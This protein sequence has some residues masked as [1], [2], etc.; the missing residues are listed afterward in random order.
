M[1]AEAYDG[2]LLE[3]PGEDGENE[4]AALY[5]GEEGV[6]L[7]DE[8][9]TG[10]F[11][12]YKAAMEEMYAGETSEEGYGEV[13]QTAPPQHHADIAQRYGD[14]P[15]AYDAENDVF[16]PSGEYRG[17]ALEPVELDVT[18]L[19]EEYDEEL[20]ARMEQYGVESEEGWAP[21][22][23]PDAYEEDI[24]GLDDVEAQLEEAYDEAVGEAQYWAEAPGSDGVSPEL[25][26]RYLEED[27]N[28]TP[29]L[30]IA[31]VEQDMP[32][33]LFGFTQPFGPKVA[34]VN[35]ALY[36]ID[37]Q[38][39]ELHEGKN[40]KGHWKERGKDEMTIRYINGDIDVQNTL[41]FQANNAGRIGNGQGRVRPYGADSF[42]VYGPQ[43]AGAGYAES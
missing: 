30:E 40:G 10:G 13:L 27:E 38:K 17:D 42:G 36:K 8:N 18:R 6:S 7:Y 3:V 35:K 31:V 33:G 1:A 9:A 28:G 29:Y 15:V 4:P 24:D 21:L 26:G 5:S 34:H 16:V 22:L 19:L 32:D 25:Y 39:T 11:E 23:E 37:K 41:S 2:P 20:D 12:A 14:A 43:D